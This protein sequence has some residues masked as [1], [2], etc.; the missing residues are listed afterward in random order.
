VGGQTAEPQPA[1]WQGTPDFAMG[2]PALYGAPEIPAPAIE[3]ARQLPARFRYRPGD[4]AV[5]RSRSG[6]G[7]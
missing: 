1:D 7:K 3:L 4:P 2:M 5:I 6:G